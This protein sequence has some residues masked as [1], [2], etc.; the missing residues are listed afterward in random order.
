MHR[1]PVGAIAR[2]LVKS[3]PDNGC[4]S[5]TGQARPVNCSLKVR[6][7]SSRDEAVLIHET[8][9]AVGGSY[10]GLKEVVTI[11]IEAYTGK[12]LHR[13]RNRVEERLGGVGKTAIA[14]PA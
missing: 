14:I 11:G 10:R 12:T 7:D 3:S 2:Q 8:N 1:I 9:K 5:R 6:S 13:V 4:L